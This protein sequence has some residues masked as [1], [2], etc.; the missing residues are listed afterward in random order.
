M[1]HSLLTGW[2]YANIPPHDF[3]DE[4]GHEAPLG[5]E[6]EFPGLGGGHWSR[7]TLV[8]LLT[9]PKKKGEGRE[10]LTFRSLP[11]VPA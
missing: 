5:G 6:V 7:R 9:L 1:F 8:L 4:G 2:F 11:T 10:L 3:L